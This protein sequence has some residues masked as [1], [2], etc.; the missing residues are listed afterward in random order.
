MPSEE[1][2]PSAESGGGGAEPPTM[3]S[4]LGTLQAAHNVR[5]D[6]DETVIHTP[7]AGQVAEILVTQGTQVDAKNLPVV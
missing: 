4:T 1:G 6:E 7:R 5:G 2:S 3:I